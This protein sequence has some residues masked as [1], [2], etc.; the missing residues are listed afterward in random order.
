MTRCSPFENLHATE[1]ET[2]RTN[3]T[4]SGD[5]IGSRHTFL[6][7][8]E[9]SISPRRNDL[10]SNF[11]P[12]WKLLLSSPRCRN[13]RALSRWMSQIQLLIR[14]SNNPNSLA[15]SHSRYYRSRTSLG[16][17]NSRM[18][19]YSRDPVHLYNARGYGRFRNLTRWR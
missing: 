4:L 15:M 12:T 17:G 1:I 7:T 16:A 18:S 10:T 5:I 13:T 14:N 2:A 11:P 19:C 9:N 3:E 6:A 8:V